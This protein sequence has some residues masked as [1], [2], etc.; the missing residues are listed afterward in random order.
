MQEPRPFE[1]E[2]VR[3]GTPC[4]RPVVLAA[5]PVGP[6]VEATSRGPGRAASWGAKE[7]DGAAAPW[8]N[9]R[10]GPSPDR[11]RGQAGAL[12]RVTRL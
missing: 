2:Y 7:R 4:K 10:R 8:G 11:C 5:R 3:D 1:R 12:A 6:V 9:A